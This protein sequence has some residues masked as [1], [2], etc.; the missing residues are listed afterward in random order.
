MIETFAGHL[1]H[2][3]NATM[4]EEIPIND[5]NSSD[6]SSRSNNHRILEETPYTQ[7]TRSNSRNHSIDNHLLL[8]IWAAKVRTNPEDSTSLEWSKRKSM[9]RSNQV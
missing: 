7:I 2:H 9:E 6:I 1:D 3:D 4:M 8:P 5:N